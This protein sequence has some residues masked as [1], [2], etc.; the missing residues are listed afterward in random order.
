MRKKSIFKGISILCAAACVATLG[1][2]IRIGYE[3]KQGETEYSNLADIM[4]S[5][6]SSNVYVSKSDSAAS[7]AESTAPI[8]VN[9]EA[10]NEMNANVVGW[11]YCEGTPI[12]YPVVQSSDNSYYLNRLYDD[13]KNSSGAIFMDAMN[14]PDLS[15]ANTIIYG[16]NMKNGTMF[17]SLQNYYSQ[18]YYEAH[19]VTYYLT[20]DNDYRIDIFASYETPGD[21]DA[22]TIFFDSE[23][24]YSDYLQ[25][26]WNMSQIDTSSLPMSTDDNI[27]TLT[28]CSYD[29]N[30]ARYV[31]QGKVTK[32]N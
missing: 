30:N 11:L 2:A 24:T 15:D 23:K 26:R 32:L 20:R 31:V 13:Q 4:V 25:K 28:T 7:A 22:F 1:Q 14:A 3:Y 10:L 19:P 16:H 27:I 18:K 5:S 21:S 8:D 17:A 6:A 29:Y 12:N 9:F